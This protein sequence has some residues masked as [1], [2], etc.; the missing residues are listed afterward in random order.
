MKN[1]VALFSILIL[2][3]TFFLLLS[4]EI[5]MQ[6][7]VQT[8]LRDFF[9]DADRVKV[10]FDFFQS[11]EPDNL[12]VALFSIPASLFIIVATYILGVSMKL[13][14][15]SAVILSLSPIHLY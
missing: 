10:V 8:F 14:I 13:R 9:K 15:S 1:N 3:Y 4:S 6:K 2:T 5:I 7:K 11:Y 12:L